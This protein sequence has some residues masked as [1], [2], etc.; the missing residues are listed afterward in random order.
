MLNTIVVGVVDFVNVNGDFA[1]VCLEGHY[2]CQ[3]FPKED[4]NLSVGDVVK[5]LVTKDFGDGEYAG[6]LLCY[7]R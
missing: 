4:D 2:G 6:E 5:V 3:V 1:S 7:E